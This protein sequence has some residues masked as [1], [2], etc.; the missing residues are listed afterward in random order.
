MVL[1]AP[2]N[3]VRGKAFH[4]PGMASFGNRLLAPRIEVS[5]ALGKFLDGPIPAQL[6]QTSQDRRNTCI[7]MEW[8]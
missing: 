3:L 6:N 1:Y 7:H 8:P 4:Q 2:Y 5:D